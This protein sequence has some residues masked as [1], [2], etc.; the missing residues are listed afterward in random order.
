MF[1]RFLR[2]VISWLLVLSS[3]VSFSS[4]F[5]DY[6]KLN[7]E[8]FFSLNTKL[9]SVTP[10]YIYVSHT[11]SDNNTGSINSPVKTIS[12]AIRFANSTDTFILKQDTYA[13][14]I[15]IGLSK[16]PLTIA[17]GYS[18]NYHLRLS[19]LILQ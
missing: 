17:L 2:Y 1:N 4:D 13:E 11:G 14:H 7:D 6:R 3:T 15:I 9:L 18:L 19:K 8:K 12:Y 5:F 16:R 10:K